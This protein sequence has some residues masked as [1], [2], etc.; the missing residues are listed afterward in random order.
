MDLLCK[1]QESAGYHL[2]KTLSSLKQLRVRGQH[3]RRTA[4]AVLWAWADKGNA[5]VVL[6][7]SMS[8]WMIGV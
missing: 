3:C 8:V 1:T 7:S 2:W 5:A 4:V 6:G